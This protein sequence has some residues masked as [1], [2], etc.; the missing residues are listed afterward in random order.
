[1]FIFS[2]GILN[3]KQNGG[4]MFFFRIKT[5]YFVGNIHNI[6][7]CLVSSSNVWK[8]EWHLPTSCNCV[9][10]VS[11][12]INCDDFRKEKKKTRKRL[13]VGISEKMFF[14][15]SSQLQAFT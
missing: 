10:V 12:S 14:M 4:L 9:S 13:N 5:K 1:M 6:Y 2:E 11:L 8:N 3:V 7:G 15:P